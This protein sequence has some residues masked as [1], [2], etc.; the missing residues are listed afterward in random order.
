MKKT[1]PFTDLIMWP[2]QFKFFHE[3]MNDLR[4]IFIFNTIKEYKDGMTYYDLTQYGNIPHSKIY[5]IMKSLEED[6]DLVRKDDISQETGRPKHLYFLSDKGAK[7]LDDL[8]KKIGEIFEFIKLRFPES[9][10]D[11]DHSKFLNEATFNV[12]SSPIE[13]IINKDISDEK[14]LKALSEIEY[15]IMRLL[16]QLHIEKGKL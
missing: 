1:F 12:W 15:D 8:R 7:K 3:F 11:L 16:K 14:K 9:N 6:G 13:F 2:K 5:R 4:M 10:S